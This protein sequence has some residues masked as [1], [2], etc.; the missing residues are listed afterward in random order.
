VRVELKFDPGSSE[1]GVVTH[2]LKPTG[3]DV[4]AGDELVEIEVD[5][6]VLTLAAP[7]AGRLVDALFLD[8]EEVRRGETVAIIETADAAEG[9]RS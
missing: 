8:G 4:S 3:S 7:A 2:W 6:V 1:F 9:G 5:K